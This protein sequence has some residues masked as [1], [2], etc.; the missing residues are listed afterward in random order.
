MIR[1]SP[2][3]ISLPGALLSDLYSPLYPVW[4]PDKQKYKNEQTSEYTPSTQK[5]RR[6]FLTWLP[7][8]NKKNQLLL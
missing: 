5:S 8:Q 3:G 4:F 2:R 1:P 6:N 7:G